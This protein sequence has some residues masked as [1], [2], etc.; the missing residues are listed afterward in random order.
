MDNF[1]IAM[2]RN[3]ITNTETGYCTRLGEHELK[4]LITLIDN[5]GVIQ[6]N[7][8]LLESAW[9]N[10]FV[11]RNSLTKAINS[12]RCIFHDNEPY[13]IIINKPRAG[14]YF[15]SNFVRNISITS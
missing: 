5:H 10:K 14:Y 9:E 1:R 4:L 11:T 13:K 2:G 3:T 15:N 7:D 12:I 8:S 6:T